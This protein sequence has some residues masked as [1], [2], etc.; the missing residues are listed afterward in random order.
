MLVLFLSNPTSKLM[1]LVHGYI[2]ERFERVIYDDICTLDGSSVWQ[3]RE[4]PLQA[5]NRFQNT[6]T[7]DKYTSE[8]I[9]MKRNI[10]W[11]ALDISWQC[12]WNDKG[13]RGLDIKQ[14]QNTANGFIKRKGVTLILS[15][16]ILKAHFIPRLFLISLCMQLKCTWNTFHSIKHGCWKLLV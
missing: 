7:K 13:A 4:N 2:L 14:I 5:K 3:G 11:Y 10:K 8:S 9:Y 1:K 12:W 6:G 16:H 15:D